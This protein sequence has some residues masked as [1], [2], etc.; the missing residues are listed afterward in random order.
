MVMQH[1]SEEFSVS[2]KSLKRNNG[3]KNSGKEVA[4]RIVVIAL[5]ME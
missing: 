1:L 3:H 5:I 4:L 2:M